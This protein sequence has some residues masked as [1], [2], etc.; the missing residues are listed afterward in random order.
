MGEQLNMYTQICENTWQAELLIC[1]IQGWE[2]SR[3]KYNSD[4]LTLPQLTIYF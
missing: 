1:Y 4:E 3:L 2:E